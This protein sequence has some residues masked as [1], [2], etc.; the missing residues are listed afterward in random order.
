M[1]SVLVK[2]GLEN[3]C[4]A[5]R[6]IPARWGKCL[7]PA[8]WKRPVSGA[9][10]ARGDGSGEAAEKAP[11]QAGMV[12]QRGKILRRRQGRQMALSLHGAEAL[13]MMLTRRHGHYVAV[14]MKPDN[15]CRRSRV[16]AVA[17]RC[18]R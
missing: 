13:Q 7:S 2:R 6:V 11:R 12:M 5:A 8:A 14:P 17:Q 15:R 10:K 1:V 9:G 18:R 4:I 3:R 16:I